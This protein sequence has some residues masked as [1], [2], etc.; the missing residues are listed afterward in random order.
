MH[1][2]AYKVKDGIVYDSET[3]DVIH[4]HD[5]LLG[6][7]TILAITPEG[8]YFVASFGGM[9]LGWVVFPYSRL[10]A[11]CW[12]LERKAP[13]EV[14]TRLGVEL[15]PEPDVAPDKPYEE[16]RV[17]ETL[18][19]KKKLFQNDFIYTS[20]FLCRNPDGRMFVFDG[21]ILLGRFVLEERRPMN[22]REALLYGIKHMATWYDLE[23]LGYARTDEEREGSKS[24][25]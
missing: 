14:L 13:D 4:H 12:A 15:I 2:R 6:H 7:R 25:E 18:C 17:C 11:V 16:L 20:E 10:M 21:M 24:A 23:Q 3:A 8:H 9:I 22:R 5:G 19:A 1:D